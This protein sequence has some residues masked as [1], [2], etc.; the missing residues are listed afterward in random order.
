VFCFGGPG[1]KATRLPMESGWPRAHDGGL[2]PSPGIG[3]VSFSNF[4]LP[5]LCISPFALMC[6]RGGGELEDLG[7]ENRERSV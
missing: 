3:G 5:P 2:G 1:G 7:G 4:H 6:F